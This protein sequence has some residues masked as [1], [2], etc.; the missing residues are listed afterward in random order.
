MIM[1]FSAFN[2]WGRS[3]TEL[4]WEAAPGQQTR[5]VSAIV[6]ELNVLKPD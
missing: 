5:T 1:K 4:R 6:A 2:A 3:D